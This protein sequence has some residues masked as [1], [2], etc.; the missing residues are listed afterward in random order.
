M[1]KCS[2]RSA[3][4]LIGYKAGDL[5]WLD[6]NGK[7]IEKDLRPWVKA[8]EQ[9]VVLRN[10]AMHITLPNQKQLIF[11]TSCSPVLGDG[12]KHAGVLVSFDD[13]TPLE[14]KKIE[15]RKSKEE[16][17][18]ANQAKSAFLANMSHEIRTP[19]NAILGF[20]EILKRGYVKNEHDSLRYL[21]IINA[22]GKNLLELINDI[23]DLSKVESGHMEIETARVEPDRIIT[24]VLQ[25]VGV[26]AQEK[27]LDLQFKAHGPQPQTIDTDPVRLRQ[28]IFN[29]TGNA[30]KFTDS[31]RVTVSSRLENDPASPHLI[32]QVEDSGI[33]IEQDKLDLIFDPFVQADA[34]TTRR[35]GGTGLGLAISR[36]FARALDGDI[37][38]TSE[39]G[40]G[41]CFITRIPTG[42]LAGVTLLEPDVVMASQKHMS[43]TKQSHWEFPEGRVLVVDDG[44]E[45]REL[46]KFLLEEAGLTVDQAENGQ[47]G[48]NKA[49]A[50]DYD[51]ILMD[52]QMPIMDGF[53]ATKLLREKGMIKPIIA[54]TANAMKGFEQQCLDA[55]YSAYLSKPIEVDGFM[56]YM[57]ELLGGRMVEA[58]SVASSESNEVQAD[59]AECTPVVTATPITSTLPLTNKK[60]RHLVGRFINRL[61]EQLQAM[62]KA[63]DE[64]NM[65]E[66]AALAHWLKGAGGTVGF[67][68][69]TKPAALLEASAKNEDK[70]EIGQILADLHAL[71]DRIITPEDN[72][73][74]TPDI[75][76]TAAETAFIVEESSE[77]EAQ[78]IVSGPIVSRLAEQP[79]FH[80]LISQFV[81]KLEEQIVIMEESW[82]R[83]D[84]PELANFAHWLKGSA[85]TLGFDEFTE[86]ASKLETS[87]N[88]AMTDEVERIVAHIRS[89]A[90]A[91]VPPAP[92]KDTK[93]QLPQQEKPLP[94]NVHAYFSD[95]DLQSFSED[96]FEQIDSEI[97]SQLHTE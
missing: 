2:E 74:S 95:D 43:E 71:A 6:A 53:T 46:V 16:A 18:S 85:G 12:K 8:L 62:D 38:V 96:Y 65:T 31:G 58:D 76:E 56:N 59:D 90:D 15:L 27:A 55:G 73:E 37:T 91:V 39:P 32:I 61:H 75:K 60:L 34:K 30:V 57:A 20:T 68:G 35:F 3:D 54:M 70:Q 11:N 9:G 87:I 72:L 50:G 97:N 89:M 14:E 94:E 40:N 69:F 84:M 63:A 1:P 67:D 51:V 82:Q 80:R 26:K 21:N 83:R 24:E 5:P 41:S 78:P 29:L 22:S 49:L 66:L 79:K 25:I 88:S 13:I 81:Q 28:I 92:E 33:G 64:D 47:I 77:P 10:Q 48:V 7:Q 4:E 86:P 17:E 44:A 36:K 93:K 19:M 45:N 52:V 42:S 23:L